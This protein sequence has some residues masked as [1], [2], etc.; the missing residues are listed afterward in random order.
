MSA[1]ISEHEGTIYVVI[2]Y[3]LDEL[4]LTEEII[5]ENVLC[6]IDT[7]LVFVSLYIH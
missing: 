3:S 7:D 2:G 1:N 5:L 6:I 4:D